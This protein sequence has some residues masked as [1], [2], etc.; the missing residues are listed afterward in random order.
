[1]DGLGSHLLGA[2]R[3]TS[4]DDRESTDDEWSET[5][6]P[7]VDGL[8]IYHQPDWLSVHVVGSDARLDSYFGRFEV[9]EIRETGGDITGVLN[10]LIVASSLPELLA[11]DPR[12][13]FRLSGDTLVL[14][15]E[16]TWRRTCKRVG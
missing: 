16:K 4:Y 3:V 2:W 5:Y 7:A 10:H 11:A 8:I 1:M 13:P 6:G 9:V 14:G 12:R 15:D